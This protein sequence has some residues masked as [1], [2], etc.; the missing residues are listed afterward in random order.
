MNNCFSIPKKVTIHYISDTLRPW[1]R[2][3]N[4]DFK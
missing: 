4:I 1:L 2:D 3:L